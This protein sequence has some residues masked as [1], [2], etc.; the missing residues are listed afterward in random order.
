MHC[1]LFAL[2]I[3]YSFCLT[4]QCRSH[5][6]GLPCQLYFCICFF[7][8]HQILS[9]LHRSVFHGKVKILHMTS[10]YH[11]VLVSCQNS[12]KLSGKAHVHSHTV[13]YAYSHSSGS[14]RAILY[15]WIMAPALM[16]C[17]CSLGADCFMCWRNGL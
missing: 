4:V 5:S 10:L 6:S 2:Q 17:W 1:F 12:R 11:L 16:I 9:K 15:H 7:P 14:G 3:F 8:M 13:L